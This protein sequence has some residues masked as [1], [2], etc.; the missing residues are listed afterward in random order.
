[1]L[2]TSSMLTAICFSASFVVGSDFKTESLR[3]WHQWRGPLADGVAPDG[4]PPIEWGRSQNI[5]WKVSIPGEGHASPIVWDD[6]V[7]V[8]TAIET[9]PGS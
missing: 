5:K 9:S 3:N 7:F 6:Q 1:M 4:D 8:L 2:K